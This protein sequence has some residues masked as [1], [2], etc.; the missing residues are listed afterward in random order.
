MHDLPAPHPEAR[1]LLEGALATDD[2]TFFGLF[3]TA[4]E[5]FDLDD[6]AAIGIDGMDLHRRIGGKWLSVIV[7]QAGLAVA[8]TI[9]FN[10]R[11]N[12]AVYSDVVLD[13]SFIPVGAKS[14][15]DIVPLAVVIL[16]DLPLGLQLLV[17]CRMLLEAD[18]NWPKIPQDLFRADGGH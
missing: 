3:D 15:G 9:P 17:G 5:I 6:E 16:S 14:V 18:P 13:A 2:S 7:S 11:S 12:D 8:Q 4:V 10:G 1:A